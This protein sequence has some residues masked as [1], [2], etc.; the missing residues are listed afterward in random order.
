MKTNPL[1]QNSDTPYSRRKLVVLV[2]DPDD[3]VDCKTLLPA[4]VRDAARWDACVEKNAG[5][6]NFWQSP[7]DFLSCMSVSLLTPLLFTSGRRKLEPDEVLARPELLAV[8]AASL[9]NNAGCENFWQ[10]PQAPFLLCIKSP[11]VTPLSLTR[12]TWK[13]SVLAPLPLR[14]D[15]PP[16]SDSRRA[17]TAGPG[18]AADALSCREICRHRQARAAS[19]LAADGKRREA[20]IILVDDGLFGFSE[21]IIIE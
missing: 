4:L 8:G 1:F 13:R 12:G 6:R 15:E 9:E 3:G 2:E 10:L 17:R 18:R 5:S 14:R 19:G 7:H 16:A 20:D 21:R 11:L